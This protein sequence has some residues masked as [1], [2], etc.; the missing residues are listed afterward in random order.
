MNLVQKINTYL[1]S[2]IAFL[3]ALLAVMLILS[4]MGFCYQMLGMFGIFIGF[5]LGAS[6]A[7]ALCGMLA[8]L[9]N[10]RD[11]LARSLSQRS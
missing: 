10:I 9:I 1:A 11:L 6:A 8:V 5:F 3:N 7:V 2:S 4:A